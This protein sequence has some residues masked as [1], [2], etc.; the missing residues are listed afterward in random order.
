[1]LENTELEIQIK[2]LQDEQGKRAD[3]VKMRKMTKLHNTIKRLTRRILRNYTR[4][5]REN[6][7]AKNDM[8]Y[9]SMK[10]SRKLYMRTMKERFQ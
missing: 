2:Y 3:K 6:T 8:F 5:W 10:C 4:R 7:N 1:M 9:A